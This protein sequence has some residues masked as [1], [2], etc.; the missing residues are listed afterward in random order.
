MP[1]L[2]FT[3]EWLRHQPQPLF[4][5]LKPQFLI[6]NLISLTLLITHYFRNKHVAKLN[7]TIF[8]NRLV[9]N[10]S[11][12]CML[13]KHKNTF[14]KVFF[15]IIC[16]SAHYSYPTFKKK[17]LH[18]W[19]ASSVDKLVKLSVKYSWIHLGNFVRLSALENLCSDKIKMKFN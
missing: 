15:P 18:T 1:K 13:R 9:P 12:S 16:E 6:I 11:F 2:V 3:I 19:A 8:N 4:G 10:N 5:D 14:D 7:L 17:L